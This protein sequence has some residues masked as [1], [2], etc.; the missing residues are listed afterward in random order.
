M[1]QDPGSTGFQPVEIFSLTSNFQDSSAWA[2]GP[3]ISD[4]KCGAGAVAF[5]RTA[6][7]GGST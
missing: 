1:A 7:G 5:E 2:V 3:P 4:E 6:E